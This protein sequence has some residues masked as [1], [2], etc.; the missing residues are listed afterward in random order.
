MDECTSTTDRDNGRGRI[1]E[2]LDLGTCRMESPSA[3]L[4]VPETD[5]C[6]QA[7]LDSPKLAK[8]DHKPL[9]QS[10]QSTTLTQRNQ[11]F[12]VNTSLQQPVAWRLPSVASTNSVPRWIGLK[13]SASPILFAPIIAGTL[14]ETNVRVSAAVERSSQRLRCCR[15]M[16]GERFI[17]QRSA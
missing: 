12:G 3:S 6:W 8:C 10:E 4:A 17:N 13:S 14:V 16:C 7:C 11:A 2:H 5:Q 1:S 9:A 15:P